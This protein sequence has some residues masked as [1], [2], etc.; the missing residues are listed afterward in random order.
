MLHGVL[1]EYVDS[2]SVAPMSANR[3]KDQPL[4]MAS[5]SCYIYAYC[6]SVIFCM[7]GNVVRLFYCHGNNPCFDRI[8][9]CYL[10]LVY[11]V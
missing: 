8:Y 9:I 2:L 7:C 6:F 11:S 1:A 3:S 10:I 4:D 5:P